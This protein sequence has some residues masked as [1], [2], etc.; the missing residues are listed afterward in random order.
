MCDAEELGDCRHAVLDLRRLSKRLP[1]EVAVRVRVSRFLHLTHSPPLL[2]PLVILSSSSFPRLYLF[3]PLAL[4]WV[5]F[6]AGN[7]AAGGW[8][9]N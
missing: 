8:G 2:P 3:P 1:Q 7:G 5:S 6:A 9:Q 4:G